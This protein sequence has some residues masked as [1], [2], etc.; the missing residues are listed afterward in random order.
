MSM[1]LGSFFFGNVLLSLS[2]TTGLTFTEGDGTADSSMKFNGSAAD[3]T[4]ALE[5]LVLT[6]GENFHGAVVLLIDANGGGRPNPTL[7]WNITVEGVNDAPSGYDVTANANEDTPYI[8]TPHH[9]GFADPEGSGTSFFS[10]H[11]LAAVKITTLPLAGSLTL[12][13][14]AVT[15]G[16]LITRVDLNAGNL[17]YLAAADASGLN[18]ASF[19][20][21]V[22]DSGGTANGGVNLD[23]TPNTMTFNVMPVND[24]PAGTDKTVALDEDTP[25]VFAASDFGYSD[26]HDSPERAF[27]AVKITTLPT[28]GTLALEGGEPL[29]AGDFVLVTVINAGLLTFTPAANASGAG[30]AHFTF[31]VLDDGVASSGGTFI[32]G[33]GGSI[34][35]GFGSPPPVV[36]I[37]PIGQIPPPIGIVPTTFNLDQSPNTMT[38]DVIPMPETVVGTTNRDVLFGFEDRDI[39]R[40]LAGNDVMLGGDENDALDGG[41]GNDILFGQNG[42]D[43]LRG[44]PGLDILYGEVGRDKFRFDSALNSST[45]VDTLAEFT[46]VDDVIQLDQTIFTALATGS[47]NAGAFYKAAGAVAA[48]DAGDRIIYDTTEGHLYYDADGAGGAASGI[49]FA[50]LSGAPAITAADFF[51]IA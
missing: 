23:P 22:Q 3:I 51:I 5:G 40:G 30:Y 47:L 21:Q 28:V 7:F 44:G 1:S 42:N 36:V 26:L 45:N 43:L 34:D 14:D 15:E 19:T 11:S 9:F 8:I 35:G 13:G 6:A 16:Q 17:E 48:S 49:R 46:P 25:Y 12:N 32:S 33:G 10:E 31:Q 41:A 18:Y 50:T 2:G 24:A 4:S 37:G 38:I 39:M 27:R 20:F 29:E